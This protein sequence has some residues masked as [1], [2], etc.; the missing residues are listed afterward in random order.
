MLFHVGVVLSGSTQHIIFWLCESLWCEVECEGL[1]FQLQFPRVSKLPPQDPCL[2]VLGRFLSAD[3]EAHVGQT[4]FVSSP[5]FCSAT[6]HTPC[7]RPPHPPRHVLMYETP[8]EGFGVESSILRTLP[9]AQGM[10]CPYWWRGMGT[11]GRGIWT[12]IGVRCV[13]AVRT[14]VRKVF[15]LRTGIIPEPEDPRTG[16]IEVFASCL[17]YACNGNIPGSVRPS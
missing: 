17:C 11:A 12:R 2:V 13:C 3:R 6:P 7:S 4:R 8:S 5:A 14:Y 1:A 9:A 15:F 10:V 16:I